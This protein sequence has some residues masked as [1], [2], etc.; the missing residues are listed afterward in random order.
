MKRFTLFGMLCVALAHTSMA[1]PQSTFYWTGTEVFTVATNIDALNFVVANGATFGVSLVQ[2]DTTVAFDTFDTLNVTNFGILIGDPGFDFEYYPSGDL[3]PPQPGVP[4]SNMAGTFANIAD[5]FGGGSITCQGS[6][7][8]FNPAAGPETNSSLSLAILKVNATNIINTGLIT[9]DNVGLIDMR[10]QNVDL[11]RGNMVMVSSLSAVPYTI[12]DWGS[13]GY[14][15]NSGGWSPTNQL[16]PTMA[17]SAIF[18]NSMTNTEQMILNNSTSFFQ[19]DSNATTG[20]VIYRGIF[21]QDFS[22]TNEVAVNVYF[23]DATVGN[24]AFHIEWVGTVKD[25]VSGGSFNDY[26]Y[27]SDVPVVRRQTNFSLTEAPDSQSQRNG[28]FTLTESTTR[29]FLGT[30]ATNSYF[31][32]WPAGVTNDFGYINAEPTVTALENLVVGQSVTNLPGRIQITSTGPLKLANSVISGPNYLSLFDTN[33]YEGNSNAAIGSPFTD[34]NLGVTNG[35]LTISNLLIPIVPQWMGITTAPSAVSGEPMGGLQAWSGSFTFI[36]TN[37]VVNSNAVP[38]TT[39]SVPYTNDVR[40]LL[41]NSAL[42]PSTPASQQN[43]NLYTSTNLVISD[44]L[45]IFNEFFSDAQTITLTTNGAGAFSSFGVLDLSLG[46]IF[47]S[48]SLPH[49]QYLTN[50]GEIDT[51]NQTFFAGNVTGAYSDLNLATPYQAFVNY[52]IITNAGT[53]IRANTFLN[54]GQIVDSGGGSIDIGS[55]GAAYGTNGQFLAPNGYVSIVANSLLA[56][57]GIIEAGGGP[58]T[59]ATTCYLSDG[60][61]FG[62]QFAHA[63]NSVFPHLVTAGNTWVASGGIDIPVKP[64]T[65]DL[66]GT[67]IFDET[68]GPNDAGNFVSLNVWPGADL[69]NN[70]QGFGD[71]LALGRLFLDANSGSQFTFSGATGNNALYVDFIEF[72]DT[73]T[74]T[75]SN[76]NLTSVVIQ[77]GMKIYYAQAVANGVSIAER[78]NG[79]NNGGFNWVSNYAGVYSSIKIHYPD[80]NIYLFND[81]LAISTNIISGGPSGFGTKVNKQNQYPIPTNTLYD[82]TITGPQ[83]CSGGSGAGGTGLN[84]PGTSASVVL[85]HL[86]FPPESLTDIGS[87]GASN[88]PPSFIL[89]AGSYNGLFYDT[90]AVAPSSSGSFSATVTSGRSFTAKLQIGAHAYSFSGVFDVSGNVAINNISGKGLAPLSVNLQLVGNDQITGVV[91]GSG[92]TSQLQADLAAFSSKNT[93]SS[94]GKDTLLLPSYEENSTTATGEGFGAATISANG[95]VQWSGTLPDG[96]KFTQ[97]SALSRNGSWPVYASLYN[98]AGVFIG[99]LQCTNQIQVAGTAVWEIPARASGLYPG[100]LT[101]QINVA[102]SRIQGSV[103][104]NGKHAAVLSLSGAGIPSSLTSQLEVFGNSVLTSDNA[105]KLSLNLQTGL[106]SGTVAGSGSI[107]KL[108]FQGA[109]LENSGIGGGFF[110]N[111]GQSG[112]VSFGPAN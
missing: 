39:N 29:Q 84:S 66:L 108:S 36:A 50:S 98:G 17:E 80:N 26:F 63:T 73:A 48:T 20:N 75:D 65:G 104:L 87:G 8:A 101:N 100:G 14:G 13:G 91:S 18:T 90:N 11:R 74:N 47:W 35:S 59:L 105:L 7:P 45:D 76:G 21:L 53:F 79:K 5:G 23:G 69:G 33:D 58:L 43:V 37:T 61:V 3:P 93:I 85:G 102:G 62:N 72:D 109:L 25:P 24:G 77:P 41:V 112:K 96:T 51:G 71:N 19:V 40:I 89:A 54:S 56:S 2:G 67:T 32:N 1:Q 27:L 60:Y 16:L 103:G 83:P 81:A 88:P 52:G 34:L 4:F 94:A 86:T 31:D 107:P 38:P 110:L 57:N 22:P 106:F 82:I 44:E 99:W 6:I 78:L 28:E 70:P 46:D 12:L 15:T 10:G 9:V 55:S 92:W 49:L 30:P 95:A 42:Q 68:F 111:A 64:A 97:K